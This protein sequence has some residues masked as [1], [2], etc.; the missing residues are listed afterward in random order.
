MMFGLSSK[1]RRFLGKLSG[2]EICGESPDLLNFPTLLRRYL[3]NK[4]AFEFVQIGANDGKYVDPL[5]EFIINNYDRVSGVVVEPMTRAFRELE[6]TYG[7]YP[8]IERLHAAIHND[9]KKAILYQIDPE[10]LRELPEFYKGIASFYCSHFDRTHTPKE[11]IIGEEVIC[12]T[13]DEVLEKYS[14]KKLDLLQIDAE[15]YDEEIIGGI[16]FD[17]WAPGMLRFEHGISQGIMSAKVFKDIA[18][19]LN[20]VGYQVVCDSYDAVAFKIDDLI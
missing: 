10:K 2:A 9:K 19:R 17:N 1:V 16:D 11:F 18:L 14:I 15:G 5:N 20:S 7:N 3:E 12:Y 4:D 13:L 6:K 8:M